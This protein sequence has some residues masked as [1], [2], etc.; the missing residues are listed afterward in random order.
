ML[1]LPCFPSILTSTC[2]YFLFSQKK[3]EK[4]PQNQFCLIHLSAPE[5][6]CAKTF[7]FLQHLQAD[8]SNCRSCQSQLHH[9]KYFQIITFM[10]SHLHITGT[11]TRVS[12]VGNNS[13][14]V[15]KIVVQSVKTL[16]QN[17]TNTV[18]PKATL[19]AEL[20]QEL[21]EVFWNF[22]FFFFGPELSCSSL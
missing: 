10:H 11:H 1:L 3:Q 6:P 17:Q 5:S 20:P 2:P 19:Y 7:P 8:G 15:V 21:M 9:T 14:K 18:M 12:A 4:T 16:S 13:E 22:F